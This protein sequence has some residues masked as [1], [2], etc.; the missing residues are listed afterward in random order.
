VFITT[1]GH[2]VG[3]ENIPGPNSQASTEVLCRV[4]LGVLRMSSQRALGAG[5]SPWG[6]F[7][8]EETTDEEGQV[9]TSAAPGA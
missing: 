2:F 1:V 9:R 5:R 8:C 3:A 7:R 4:C 6:L